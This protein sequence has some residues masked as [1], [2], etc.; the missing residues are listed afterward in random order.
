[1]NGFSI[2]S[3]GSQVRLWGGK[4]INGAVDERYRSGRYKVI[5]KSFQG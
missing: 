3:K 1:M 2:G 4:D 5:G